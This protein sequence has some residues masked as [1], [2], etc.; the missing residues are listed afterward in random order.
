MLNWALWSWSI[1]INIRMMHLKGQK[2]FFSRNDWPIGTFNFIN[3][4]LQRWF[5]M[6]IKLFVAIGASILYGGGMLFPNL[7]FFESLDVLVSQDQAT[8]PNNNLSKIVH[9]WWHTTYGK[10]DIDLFEV[11]VDELARAITQMFCCYDFLDFSKSQIGVPI[12]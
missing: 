11:T 9:Y 2:C 10:R 6:N 7:L 1:G 8:P 5:V 3:G 12:K 4:G